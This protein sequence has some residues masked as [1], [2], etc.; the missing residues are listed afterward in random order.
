M[1]LQ[2]G[3]TPGHTHAALG[4][5]PHDGPAAVAVDKPGPRGEDPFHV[6]R[7]ATPGGGGAATGVADA[8]RR[9]S[10]PRGVRDRG[11]AAA[12]AATTTTVLLLSGRRR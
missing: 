12:T 1:G 9:G 8:L 7:G 3:H 10:R 11:T 2:R 5:L 6:E 4:A